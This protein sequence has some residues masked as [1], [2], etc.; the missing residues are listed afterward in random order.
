MG[1]EANGGGT[2]IA[3]ALETTINARKG[4]RATAIFLLTDGDVHV[5]IILAR[6]MHLI[7]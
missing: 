5:R 4:D 6:F 1:L 2:Q 7:S 3:K